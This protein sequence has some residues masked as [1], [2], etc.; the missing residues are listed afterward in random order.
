MI[1]K[2]FCGNILIYFLHRKETKMLDR[3]NID[4]KYKWDLTKI[5]PTEE[6]FKADFEQ[7]EAIVKEF[8]AHEK[9]MCH[10]AKGLLAVLNDEARIEYLISKLWVYAHLYFDTDNSNKIHQARMGRGRSLAVG[11]SAASWFVTPYI[12]RL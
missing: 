8:P 10:S 11:A 6:D 9:A 1:F 4:P 7:V 5:Y 3:K 2:S 12:L